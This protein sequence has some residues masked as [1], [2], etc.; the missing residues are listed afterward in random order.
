MKRPTCLILIGI[1]VVLLVAGVVFVVPW[2]TKMFDEMEQITEQ[3]YQHIHAL[4]GTAR[5]PLTQAQE[6]LLSQLLKVPEET[7][8]SEDPN[9]LES[10]LS[11][12]PYLAYLKVLEG[13]DYEDYPAYIAAMPTPSMK[14]AARSRVQTTLVADNGDEEL[15]IWMNYYFKVREW[16]TTVEDPVSNTGEHQELQLSNA[17]EHQELQ[18]KY[19]IEPLMEID[20]EISGLHTK[21]VQIGMSSIF[22]IEDNK[23]FKEV[24]RERLETHGE[25]EGLLRCAIA[26]PEEFGLMRSFFAD[27]NAFQE[28]ILRLP[29]PEEE[30]EQPTE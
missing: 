3:H 4:E 28:W 22:M 30:I 23:V 18:E 25:Q 7:D 6:E 5:E 10:V 14:T 16:G 15:E 20:S 27:M 24:W 2:F 17:A 29:E 9:D 11:S 26:S 8:T 19:L 1:G 12:E 21:I 13:E